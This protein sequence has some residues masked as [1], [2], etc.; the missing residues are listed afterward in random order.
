MQ[1]PP[2]RNNLPLP[3][4]IPPCEP[5]MINN[6]LFQHDHET[7]LTELDDIQQVSNGE[8]RRKEDMLVRKAL[9]TSM[10]EEVE[11]TQRHNIFYTRC[12]ILDRMCTLVVD[13]ASCDNLVSATLVKELKLET[14]SHPTPCKLQWLNACGELKVNGDYKDELICG[15]VPLHACH[16]ILGRPWLYDRDVLH[17]GRKNHYSLKWKGKLVTLEPL[18]PSQVLKAQMSLR[19]SLKNTKRKSKDERQKKERSEGEK[20]DNA[21]VEKGEE[22]WSE[23]SELSQENSEELD[24]KMREKKEEKQKESEDFSYSNTTNLSSFS[25]CFVSYVGTLGEEP[26]SDIQPT[27]K[28]LKEDQYIFSRE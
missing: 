23:V 5:R 20:S 25:S 15:V 19:T 21:R 11:N 1:A 6:P 7:T 18:E 4:P 26:S 2:K 28:R 3:L 13:G 22:V 12:L 24:K 9:S 16:I 14:F 10:E 27:L 8:Y 17:Q